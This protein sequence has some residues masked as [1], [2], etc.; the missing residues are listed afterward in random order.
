L[1]FLNIQI[2]LVIVLHRFRPI[3]VHQGRTASAAKTHLLVLLTRLDSEDSSAISRSISRNVKARSLTLSSMHVAF[4]ERIEWRLVCK[5]CTRRL[6]DMIRSLLSRAIG[7]I[8]VSAFYTFRIRAS[9]LTL[10]VWVAAFTAR[11]PGLRRPAVLFI[12]ILLL[13]GGII[14]LVF[15]IWDLIAIFCVLSACD[16]KIKGH[17]PL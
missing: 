6:R 10:V 8:S 12:L 17:S 4:Q 15:E 1:E 11:T 16:L 9:A 3:A 2:A 5:A 14:L 13:L 7:L